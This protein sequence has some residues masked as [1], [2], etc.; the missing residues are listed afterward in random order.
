MVI[1]WWGKSFIQLTANSPQEGEVKLM[2]DPFAVKTIGL[3]QPKM[4]VDL[5]LLTQ[6]ELDK[7][8]QIK[9]DYFLV[10]EPG[11]YEVKQIFIYGI[12]ELNKDKQPSGRIFYLIEA[13]GISVVHLGLGRQVDF[14]DKQLEFLENPDVL[15][16]PVGGGDSLTARQAAEVVQRL[17][18]RFIVPIN[19]AFP[20]AKVKLDK[21][22]NFIKELGIKQADSK[23][24]LKISS[25]DLVGKESELFVINP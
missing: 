23:D 17:E 22:D 4:E 8:V 3:R 15:L 7:D 21:V 16:V 1:R 25:K 12:P 9:G 19:F 10:N 18:P 14:T 2:V 11:E 5:V 20:G 24:K 13:E 6:G